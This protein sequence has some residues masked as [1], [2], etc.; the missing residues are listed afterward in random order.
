MHKLGIHKAIAVY[1]TTYYDTNMHLLTVVEDIVSI[2]TLHK[3]N[4][5]SNFSVKCSIEMY[6]HQE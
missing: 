5:V 2:H 6:I 3:L 1:Y 4:D